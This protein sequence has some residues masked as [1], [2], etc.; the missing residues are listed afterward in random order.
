MSKV[1][2]LD[3]LFAARDA[4]TQKIIYTPPP[5]PGSDGGLTQLVQKREQLSITIQKVIQANLT[6]SMQQVDDAIAQINDYTTKL[7]DLANELQNVG[8]AITVAAQI[9]NVVMT[10]LAVVAAA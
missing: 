5:P 1:E 9:I 7:T 2:L 3:S 10:I 4:L 6:A 8:T